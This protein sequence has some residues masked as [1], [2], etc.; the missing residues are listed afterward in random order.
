MSTKI[1]TPDGWKDVDGGKW[2]PQLDWENAVKIGT[3]IG[4]AAGYTAPKPGIVVCTGQTGV[5]N[6][7][8]VVQINGVTVGYSALLSAA[9][10]VFDVNCPVNQG[11]I[12]KHVD[13]YTLQPLAVSSP[14][15]TFAGYSY[16]FIP[17]KD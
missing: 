1:K 6:T 9:S 4:T 13:P 5:S 11:D 7:Y 8:S 17:Y 10:W 14:D 2:I 12:I 15:E 16:R 3:A